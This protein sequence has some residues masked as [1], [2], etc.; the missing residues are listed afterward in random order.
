MVQR[1]EDFTIADVGVRC[2]ALRKV[3]STFLSLKARPKVKL[4]SENLVIS[5]RQELD[6]FRGLFLNRNCRL[7]R[8]FRTKV[9]PHLMLT[10]NLSF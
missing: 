2:G 1:L 10:P 6:K 8:R 4:D 7:R 5:N 3:L 9:L